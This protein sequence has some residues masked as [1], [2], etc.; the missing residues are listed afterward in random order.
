MGMIAAMGRGNQ[1]KAER[2]QAAGGQPTKAER[3][4]AKA[5]RKQKAGAET[6]GAVRGADAS[7]DE[8]I[9]LRL[10]RIEEAVAT[11]SEVSEQLLEKLDEVLHEARK[12]ARHAKTA[13]TQPEDEGSE[14]PLGAA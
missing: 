7:T 10:A 8:G 2:R 5:G 14:E 13:V 9:E 3:R 6:P 1:T 4:Q 12:S 11:Q